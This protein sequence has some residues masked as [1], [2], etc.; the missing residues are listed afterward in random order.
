MGVV[1]LIE[2][3]TGDGAHWNLHKTNAKAS[4]RLYSD[5]R[6]ASCQFSFALSESFCL[7][8]SSFC[9]SDLLTQISGNGFPSSPRCGLS[10]PS[11]RCS[12]WPWRCLP[13]A[14]LALLCSAQMGPAVGI[15]PAPVPLV[16][17]TV[18]LLCP[19]P[20]SG[21]WP[22]WELV[23]ML[24]WVFP[25]KSEKPQRPVLPSMSPLQGLALWW[26]RRMQTAE[27]LPRSR[28][29]FAKMFSGGNAYSKGQQSDVVS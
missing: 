1:F 5:M 20:C 17:R 26:R 18:S 8:I 19:A 2:L 15:W 6:V 7:D 27:H 10:A 22:C 14:V 25:E 29:W 21:V 28:A 16:W 11:S 13:S 23:Y 3:V 12:P 4:I 24:T 9:Y